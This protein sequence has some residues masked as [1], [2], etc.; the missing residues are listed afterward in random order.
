MGSRAARQLQN[1]SIACGFIWTGAGL[2]T[3]GGMCVIM[4]GDRA[5]VDMIMK[6]TD[7]TF[8]VVSPYRG[9]GR[10]DAC[11]DVAATGARLTIDTR[12][13]FIIFSDRQQPKQHFKI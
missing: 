13:F 7:T 10:I 4:P 12:R 8:V 6:N 3:D 5:S 11:L 1:F 9:R 2:R